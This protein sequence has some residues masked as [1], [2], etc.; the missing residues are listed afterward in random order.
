MLSPLSKHSRGIGHQETLSLANL[1]CQWGSLPESSRECLTAC[2]PAPAL[3]REDW[4]GLSVVA[5][6]I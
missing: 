6:L 4:V 2:P 5:R 1:I 3:W